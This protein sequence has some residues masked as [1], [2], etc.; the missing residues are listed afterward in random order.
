MGRLITL[1]G[2][3]GV[4]KDFI[5][6]AC[7]QQIDNLI[8]IISHTTRPIRQGEIEGVNYHFIDTKTATEM[9]NNDEFIETR[10]YYVANK[11]TWLYGIHKDEIDLGS[12]NNY[13]AIVDLQGLKRI[14]KYLEKNNCRDRLTSIYVDVDYQK[15]LL[16]ALNREGDMTNGQ[17]L[18]VVR[19]LQDDIEFVD[20]AQNHCDVYAKNNGLMD[21]FGIVKLI[22]RIVGE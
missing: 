3:Q 14:E 19:R 4:G 15:R 17:V 1:T 10:Q 6:Q 16:R 18:E 11:E 12:N 9:L 8:P 5:L 22:E 20:I 13:I 21:L 7:L 2:G